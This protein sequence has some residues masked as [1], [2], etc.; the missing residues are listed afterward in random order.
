MI[1]KSN[2]HAGLPKKHRIISPGQLEALTSPLRQDIITALESCRAPVSIL[3]IAEL[4]ARP[5]DSLYYH[6]RIL[7]KAALIKEAGHREEHGKPVQLYLP[8]AKSI[9]I[10]YDLSSS[11]FRAVL[12]KVFRTAL[13]LTHRNFDVAIDSKTARSE[14]DSRNIYFCQMEANLSANKLKQLN[15]HIEGIREIMSNQS[16]NPEGQRCSVF[17]A[18]SEVQTDSNLAD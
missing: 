9:Q 15:H 11:R 7:E 12:K 2:T 6:F 4:L 8:I 10:K 18:L 13:K 3:E 17:L 14:S 1:R 5:A 16:A